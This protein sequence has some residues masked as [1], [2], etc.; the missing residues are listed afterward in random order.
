MK[1]RKLLVGLGLSTLVTVL[2]NRPGNA[3]NKEET[4]HEVEFLFVQNASKATIANGVLTLGGINPSTLY[5]SDRPDRI[6]GHV[7]TREFVDHWTIGKDS[8]KSDP[9]NATLTILARSQPEGI[10]VVLR[11][12]RLKGDELVYDVEVLDGP[13]SVEG[14]QCS[15]FIDMF[16]R[17]LS[18]LSAAGVH[19]RRRRRRRHR[20]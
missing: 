18:P 20:W 6:V 9:P 4:P 2:P 16:G 1:R 14:E 13:K 7:T 11:N 5:F 12:P 15:L 19:R 17:P 3:Q 10:V 8:F